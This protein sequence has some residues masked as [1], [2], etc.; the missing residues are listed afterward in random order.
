VLVG[1]SIVSIYDDNGGRPVSTGR[2]WLQALAAA[3]TDEYHRGIH[4]KLRREGRTPRGR[5]GRGAR[6]ESR[7]ARVSVSGVGEREAAEMARFWPGAG[8]A[9]QS[10]Y[11]E[12]ADGR[13]R[14]RS[15][16]LHRHPSVN[17][18]AR[19]VFLSVCVRS[20]SPGSVYGGIGVDPIYGI[21]PPSGGG[22]LRALVA[23]LRRRPARET[24]CASGRGARYTRR[25]ARASSFFSAPT[26]A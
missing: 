4:H 11:S 15:F 3:I 22:C 10:E 18:R 24:A 12:G 13:A 2:S 7:I 21:M 19:D 6:T 26:A 14:S 5:R 25:S 16:G 9:L 20:R 23:E 8:R 1:S 17:T